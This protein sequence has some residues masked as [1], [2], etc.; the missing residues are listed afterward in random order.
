MFHAQTQTP[1]HARALLRRLRTAALTSLA[2]AGLGGIA[3]SPA[4]ADAVRDFY[5]G[6][7]QQYC[8]TF[9]DHGAV[10]GHTGPG[11]CDVTAKM[12]GGTTPKVQFKFTMWEGT[13]D[14]NSAWSPTIYPGGTFSKAMWNY[15]NT[16]LELWKANY[17]TLS[18]RLRVTGPCVIFP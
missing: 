2:L 9:Y 15:N 14:G 17:G 18:Y 11:R 5:C 7:S 10:V 8:N 4:Q 16:Y 3:T 6:T 12:L 13:G 1:I